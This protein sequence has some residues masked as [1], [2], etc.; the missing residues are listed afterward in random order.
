M[1]TDILNLFNLSKIAIIV[2]RKLPV[3]F[4]IQPNKWSTNG[5]ESV[6]FEVSEK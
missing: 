3:G 2:G 1:I 5:V 4:S 6:P